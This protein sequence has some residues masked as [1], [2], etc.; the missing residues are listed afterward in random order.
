MMPPATI[1]VS[2]SR[3]AVAK[4]WVATMANPQEVCTGHGPGDIEDLRLVE[5]D[6]GNG[7]RHRSAGGC[8]S[9]CARSRRRSSRSPPNCASQRAIGWG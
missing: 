3:R 9:S 1:S 8:S 4:E 7:D 5:G 6:E 2:T